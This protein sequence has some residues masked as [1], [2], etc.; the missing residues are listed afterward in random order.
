MR[1]GRHLFALA[2]L[3]PTVLAIAACGPAEEQVDPA[4]EAA[5][6]DLTWIRENKPVLDAKR[7]ETAGLRARLAG[8]EP[9]EGAP[10]LVNEETGEPL[11]D[12]EIQG[13]V[14]ALDAE[15]LEMEDELNAKVANFL[16][17]TGITPGEPLSPDQRLVMDIKVAEDVLIAR[18]YIDKGGDYSRAIDIF[19]A[20]LALDPDNET[21]QAELQRAEELRFMD[22][23]R[24]SQ[25]KKGMTQDEVRALLGTVKNTNVQEFEDR[26]VI[27]W[28]YRKDD[29]GTAGIFFKERNKGNGDWVVYN[30]DFNLAERQVEGGG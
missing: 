11:T 19:N 4:T 30:T 9:E 8:D 7:E 29:G 15:I 26:G 1:R 18:E 5:T 24:F 13:R 27:G 22:E 14:T 20:T 2:T 3:V 23:E 12:E 16:N 21:L 25:A 28:F 17:A 6:A 10:E